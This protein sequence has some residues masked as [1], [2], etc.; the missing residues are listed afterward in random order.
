MA[1]S[2]EL[3]RLELLIRDFSSQRDSLVEY[4]ESHKALISFGRRLP[5]DV[6]QGIFIA[7]LPTHRNAIMSAKEAPFLL[8]HICSGWQTI[9]LSTAAL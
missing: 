1:H 5:R 9:A 2:I 8:C 4:I 3:A 7:C 6:V